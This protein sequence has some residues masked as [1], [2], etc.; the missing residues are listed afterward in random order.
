MVL[1]VCDNWELA[2]RVRSL[3]IPAC[4]VHDG[5]ASSQEVL[6]EENAD[7]VA[8][9]FFGDGTCNVGES[10]QSE[11]LMA[12]LDEATLQTERTCCTHVSSIRVALPLPIQ[13]TSTGEAKA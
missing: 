2:E 13:C 9:N 4:T 1:D 7:Q 6:G 10:V 11:P 8:I 5:C 3:Q 12:V